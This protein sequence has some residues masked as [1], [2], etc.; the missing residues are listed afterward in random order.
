MPSKLPLS[1]PRPDAAGAIAHLMGKT[2]LDRPPLVEYIVDETIMRPVLE[3]MGSNW[4]VP[5]HDT[6]AA[7]LDNFARFYYRLGYSL[8]KFERSLSFPAHVL[9]TA[10]TAPYVQRDRAWNDQ[11]Q[12]VITSWETFEKYTW[13]TIETF[14]FSDFDLLNRIL[15]DGMG[16]MVSH[17]GGP[18]EIL[19]ALMAYEGLCINLYDQ[20]DLV[21]AV[22]DRVGELMLRFYQHLLTYDRVVALFPGD[23]MGFRSGTLISPA[24]LR[25]LT[26][27]WHRRFAGLAHEK[28]LPY[29][30]HSCGNLAG[31]MED[32]IEYVKID[33]K[34][35]YEDAIL[36]VEQFQ[37]RY[38]PRIAV[39]GGIDLN[40][41]TQGSPE[42]V[43]AR[44]RQVIETCMP[45]GR[46]AIGSGN[47][48]PSYIPVENYLA[49]IDAALDG[50]F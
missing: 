48:I 14:D 41:L 13:P 32:L 12:G 4:V 42:S 15:P 24:H 1:N 44:T 6:K 21:K 17:A 7:Y 29:F 35:S 33:G 50:S 39:L 46:Y 28:G 11:H 25:A 31:I 23:D 43:R 5:T 22:A 26:L 20:F 18:Y 19:S 47:S 49:M 8:V 9:I 38:G 16:L 40:T 10:D 37:A 34:H 3:Q 30:L 36:P 45:R 2:R 27:P